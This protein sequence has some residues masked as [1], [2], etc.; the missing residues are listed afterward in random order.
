MTIIIATT[1]IIIITI[2]TTTLI[3]IIILITTIINL[4]IMPKISMSNRLLHIAINSL[5]T[6]T[7][8]IGHYPLY[9]LIILC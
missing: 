3:M 4:Q 1:I 8:I 7:V 2:L 9:C 6:V 5:Y